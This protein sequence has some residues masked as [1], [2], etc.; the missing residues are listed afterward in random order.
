MIMSDKPELIEVPDAEGGSSMT[1]WAVIAF[2]I[3]GGLIVAS[4]IVAVIVGAT[5]ADGG[6]AI[7]FQI[8][9]DVLII[10]LALQGVF[11][12]IAMVVLILQ[13][14]ALLNLL[15][16]EVKP[17]IQEVRETTS[18]ARGTAQ[19]VSK[20]VAE[21][22]IRVAS[23]AAFVQTFLGEVTGIRRNIGSK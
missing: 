4:L 6:L 18:A 12:S 2:G 8:V 5:S 17:L 11:L 23:V 14:S 3:L 13:F 9:R 21:P 22:V 20:N 7:G 1:R 19:F 16:N 10:V 15:R